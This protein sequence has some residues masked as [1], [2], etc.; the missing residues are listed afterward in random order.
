MND[1]NFQTI[2]T[3]VKYKLPHW[4]NQSGYLWKVIREENMPLDSETLEPDW[5]IMN[6]LDSD[7]TLVIKDRY[8]PSKEKTVS[9]DTV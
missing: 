4:V 9:T 5:G 6:L 7:L 8:L 1:L 2:E 3:E